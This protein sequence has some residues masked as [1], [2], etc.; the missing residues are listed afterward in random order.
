MYTVRLGCHF[1]AHNGAPEPGRQSSVEG[2]SVFIVSRL[3]ASGS[4]ALA[5]SIG[6]ART[7]GCG[8]ALRSRSPMDE[9][10]QRGA[11]VPRCAHP[12]HKL[13]GFSVRFIQCFQSVF[14]NLFLAAYRKTCALR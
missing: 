6:Y 1:Q 14:T 12:L 13:T 5:V 7:G 9:E 10:C 4:L 11:G 2:I 8:T 3:T